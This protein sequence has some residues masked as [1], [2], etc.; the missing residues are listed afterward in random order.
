MAQ[1][2]AFDLLVVGADAAGF[3]AAAAAMKLGVRAAI[4]RTGCEP[5]AL[6]LRPSP[7]NFVWRLLDLHRHE[8]ATVDAGMTV[9]HLAEGEEI[10][11][12]VDPLK[13][14]RLLARRD[15]AL[16]HYWPDFVSAMALA[17]EA[18]AAS[19]A[20]DRRD[21]SLGLPLLD[22]RWASAID[23][24][25]DRFTD[26]GLKAH[27]LMSALAPLGLAGDEP[28]SA[29]ALFD[30]DGR[31]P[32]QRVD[33]EALHDALAAAA[34]DAGVVV[35]GGKLLRLS[36]EGDRV[37]TAHLE[38]GDDVRAARAIA[39]SA[40]IAD[41]AGLVVEAGGSPLRRQ[42]GAEAT[43]RLRYARKPRVKSAAAAAVHHI[44]ADKRALQ[45][46]RDAMLEGRLDDS[47]PLSFEVR[48]R[49]IIARAP[50]AP[51]SI[52]DNGA[53]RDWTGQDLQIL[54]RAA[55]AAIG[56]RLDPA[57]GAPQAVDASLGADVAAGLRKR[58]FSQSPITAPPPSIDAVGAAAALVMRLVRP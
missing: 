14:A 24:L 11:T 19:G 28:G 47:M 37:V 52:R 15:P 22:P 36:R 31:D 56:R 46:A 8:V 23:L 17:K 4:V 35:G 1:R 53:M 58:D 43:I 39:S 12:F 25:D 54:G 9:T 32:A 44:A 55:A 45:R 48:G 38:D 10:G 29:L 6:G 3:A 20:E 41:A 13:T 34:K 30:A 49:E 33:A 27:V 5:K 16:E 57:C 18:E 26:E 42:A 40:F 7:P 50:Y 2:P 21:S 51:A